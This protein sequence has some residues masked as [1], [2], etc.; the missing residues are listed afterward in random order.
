MDKN[1]SLEYLNQ[2]RYF[3]GVEDYEEALKYINKAIE[4]DKMNIEFYIEKGIILANMDRYDDAI[5]E[6]NNLMKTVSSELKSTKNK[7]ADIEKALLQHT[8]SSII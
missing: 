7:V 1:D 5:K 2:S 4:I 3:V 8:D 6:L